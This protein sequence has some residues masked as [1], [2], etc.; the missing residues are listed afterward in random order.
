MLRVVVGV[1][2]ITASNRQ[3][4]DLDDVRS[5]KDSVAREL[6]PLMKC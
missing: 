4:V 1:D 2:T 5:L 3:A 6:W